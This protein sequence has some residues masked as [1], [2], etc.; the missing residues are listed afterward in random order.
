MMLRGVLH[1]GFTVANMDRSVEF[2]TRLFGI[3]PFVHRVYEDNYISQ[4]VGYAGARLDTALYNIPHSDTVLE[5]IQ[6]LEPKGMPVN[7]ETKNPGTAHLCLATTDLH[8]DFN[9]MVELG[10]TPRSEGPV[11]ITS[12]INQGLRVCYF[13]DHDG[14]TIELLEART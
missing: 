5:L 4:L 2:Y 9:R 12:G 14:I 7:T 8:A 6:Y 11:K 13:R 10:A 3:E 1:V